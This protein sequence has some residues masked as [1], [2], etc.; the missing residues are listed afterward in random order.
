MYRVVPRI[1]D[2]FAVIRPDGTVKCVVDDEDFAR[3]IADEC[4]NEELYL[5][6]YGHASK[7]GAKP[8]LVMCVETGERYNSITE[9]AKACHVT[10]RTIQRSLK[11]GRHGK[12]TFIRVD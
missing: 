9:A 11:E 2:R 3:E 4:T 10:P 12:L 7:P 1:D 5:T 6:E 8:K